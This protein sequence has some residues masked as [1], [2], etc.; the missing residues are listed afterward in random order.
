MKHRQDIT[1]RRSFLKSA[2][3]L[4]TI[5]VFYGPWKS[6][7]VYAS[8]NVKP[9]KI[10][11]T[12]DATGQYGASGQ[13]DLR[14]CIT[15]IEAFNQR[16]GIHGRPVEYLWQDTRTDPHA[17]HQVATSMIHEYE[18][19]FLAGAV[20]SSV[21]NS[22]AQVAQQ[23][24][25]VY[26]NTNSS[27]PSQ[28]SEDCHRVKFVFD[29]NSRNFAR[30]STQYAI[31]TYGDRWVILANDYGWGHQSANAIKTLAQSLG[32]QIIDTLFVPVGTRNYI[33]TLKKIKSMKPQVVATAIGGNDYIPLRAQ[34]VD[35]ELHRSPVWVNNQQDWPDHY[36]STEAS[37]FGIFGTTWYHCLEL[38]GV[39][40]FVHAYQQRW[41]NNPI[42]VPGNVYYNGYMAMYELLSAIERAGSTN[43]HAVI[44]ELEN[45]KVS[46]FD[47]MQHADAYMNANSHHLQQT[48]Y[49]ATSNN[50]A[51]LKNDSDFY[52][53]L[54]WLPPEDIR[55]NGEEQ[56]Q[57]ESI[58][59]TPTYET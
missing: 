55:D 6:N 25:C 56:C 49:I 20:H 38:P 8:N 39:K 5:P 18:V 57:L 58:Q 1:H 40:E 32:A 16:G 51:D 44:R 47:R 43:N 34:V 41:K 10:G 59:D 13:S 46:A 12:H 33:G 28:A 7:R 54:N 30:A 17:A 19:S 36:A 31:D 37:I 26:L 48:V 14:G 45:L 53:I 21:A 11:L 9:I 29:A 42:M 4:S 2:L 50:K 35:M 52:K 15:A 23:A 27:S 24:G 22:I 3:A